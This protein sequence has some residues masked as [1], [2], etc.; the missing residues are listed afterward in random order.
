MKFDTERS[1]FLAAWTL[2]LILA[3]QQVTGQFNHFNQFAAASSSHNQKVHNFANLNDPQDKN[4]Q[5]T[6]ISSAFDQAQASG[7]VAV[8]TPSS[9]ILATSTAVETHSTVGLT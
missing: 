9:T 1:R 7:S 2:T 4:A 3:V 6:A 8:P 5:Q